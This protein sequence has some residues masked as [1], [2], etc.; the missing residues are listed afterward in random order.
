MRLTQI[1]ILKMLLATLLYTSALIAH[2]VDMQGKYERDSAKGDDVDQVIEHVVEGMSF[3]KRPIA[4]ARLKKTNPIY[5]N[6]AIARDAQQV[7]VTFNERKP[8]LMPADGKLVEWTREDGEKFQISAG[9]S[10]TQLVQTYDAPDGKRVD[11]FQ[12]NP[13]DNTLVLKVKI[14]SPQLPE[15]LVY[16]ETYR[17]Q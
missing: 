15:P 7:S 5:K 6:I 9:W 3:Y 8:I 11:T 10:D 13:N 4:R 2:A 14:T 16:S 1:T 12:F 17:R